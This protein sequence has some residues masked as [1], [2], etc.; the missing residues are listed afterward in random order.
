MRIKIIS[1]VLLTLAAF[2]SFAAETQ[3]TQ[4][5]KN[6]RDGIALGN[7]A[8]GG[9][10]AGPL[11]FVAGLIAGNWLGEKVIDSYSSEEAEQVLVKAR[12]ENDQLRKRFALLDAENISL[13]RLLADSLQFQEL[14]H[15][16]ESKLSDL[17]QARIER[18]AQLVAQQ[19]SL[20][21]HLSGFADPRG[22]S[23]YNKQL[24]QQRMDSII[25]VLASNGVNADRV[26]SEAF[27][28]SL[29]VATEGDYDAYALER[30]VSIELVR[31]ID[32]SSL[33]AR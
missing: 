9:V 19:D 33:A 5:Q 21:V 20:G 13:Q 14:F 3:P 29:S 22:G 12:T 10:I 4:A 6:T 31:N 2:N 30:R 28:D 26:S 24:S 15:T 23:D 7:A 18:I 1:A 27:G 17:G 32:T 11:G 8:A 25:A 16:G